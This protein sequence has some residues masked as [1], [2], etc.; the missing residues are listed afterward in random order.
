MKHDT[1]LKKCSRLPHLFT[2]K[3]LA[4]SL[5][6]ATPAPGQGE[7]PTNLLAQSV[8]TIHRV[9]AAQQA[10]ADTLQKLLDR[11]E[12]LEKKG[13]EQNAAAQSLQKK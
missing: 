7:S 9:E 10:Q 1:T 4:L 13:A 6:V 3:W 5:A 11:I 2:V 12:Q 8:Q